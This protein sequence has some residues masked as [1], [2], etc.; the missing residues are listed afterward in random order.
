MA[1]EAP[2]PV[3]VRQPVT[4]PKTGLVSGEWAFW[5]EQLRTQLAV[6]QTDNAALRARIDA[7]EALP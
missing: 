7:L 2:G 6:V 5:F 3:L 1:T 4:D